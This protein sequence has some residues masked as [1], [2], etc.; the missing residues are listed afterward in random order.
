[1]EISGK[2][3]Q[4][5]KGFG[6][7]FWTGFARFRRTAPLGRQKRAGLTKKK[8]LLSRLSCCHLMLNP[9]RGL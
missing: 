4:K 3:R 8:I 1:V 7:G 6:L 5:T 9:S 2:N